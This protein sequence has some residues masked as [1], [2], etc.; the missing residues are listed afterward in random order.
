MYK[1]IFSKSDGLPMLIETDDFD[2]ETYTDVQ[3]PNG[4]YQ[5]IH[6]DGNEWIGTPYDEWLANQPKP[7]PIEPNPIEKAAA[8][9]Q[10]QVMKSNIAQVQLQKQNAQMMLEIAKLKG[11]N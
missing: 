5:P 9:L 7:E 6:F 8:N 10:M 4:L 1:Q 11:G 3:P 2:T